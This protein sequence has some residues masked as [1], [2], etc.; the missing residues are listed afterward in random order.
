MKLEA[1][2]VREKGKPFRFKSDM[3]VATGGSFDVRCVRRGSV[4]KDDSEPEQPR[5]L[6]VL[7]SDPPGYGQDALPSDDGSQN[8]TDHSKRHPHHAIG[9]TGILAAKLRNDSP[10][11][12]QGKVSVLLLVV[13]RR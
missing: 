2:G 12:G 10:I 7:R 13:V 9:N 3:S 4:E 8:T 1:T 11:S 6:R 5:N